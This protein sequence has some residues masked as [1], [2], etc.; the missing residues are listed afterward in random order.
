[1]SSNTHRCSTRRGSFPAYEPAHPHR[2]S[3][4][5]VAYVAAS[6]VRTEPARRKASKRTGESCTW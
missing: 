6:M 3:D 1:M 5:Q 2:V 4:L